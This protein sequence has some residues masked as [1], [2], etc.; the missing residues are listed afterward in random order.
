MDRLLNVMTIFSALL[1]GLVLTSVRRAHIRVEYSVSWLV[2]GLVI[3][4]LSRSRA[5]L[6]WIA[7]LLGVTQTGPAAAPFALLMVTGTLFMIVLYRFSLRISSLK[8]S[9]I[10]LAQRVAIL[11][12]RLESLDEKAKA[13]AST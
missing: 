5:A 1:I 2:A 13:A 8:D 9:N 4:A 12:F 6:G 3:L 7:G 11:E 10:A